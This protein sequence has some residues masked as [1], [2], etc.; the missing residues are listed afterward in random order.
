MVEPAQTWRLE[1]NVLHV[2]MTWSADGRSF[3][4][5]ARLWLT[6]RQLLNVVDLFA[7]VRNTQELPSFPGTTSDSTP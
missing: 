1:G 4:L 5:E 6:E 2:E 7:A 3:G